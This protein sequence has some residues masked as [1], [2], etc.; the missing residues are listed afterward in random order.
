MKTPI[1]KAMQA[2]RDSGIKRAADHANA[3]REG[4]TNDAYSMLRRY[5]RSHKGKTFMAEDVRAWAIKRGMS[6]PPDN[7]AWG[8]IFKRASRE[9]VIKSIGWRTQASPNCHGSPKNLWVQA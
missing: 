9:F 3:Q 6:N 5:M 4:W 1:E 8:S 7:R 2:M